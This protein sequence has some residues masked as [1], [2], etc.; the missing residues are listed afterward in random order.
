MQCDHC[1]KDT[2]FVVTTPHRV[3]GEGFDVT[4]GSGSN[5]IYCAACAG[6]K[7]YQLR[8]IISGILNSRTRA[9]S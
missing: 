8:G 3:V 7:I 2:E 6:Y 9:K 1:N 4:S 5:E